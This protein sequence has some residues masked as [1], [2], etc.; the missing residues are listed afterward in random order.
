[1]DVAS[2]EESNGGRKIVLRRL[3]QDELVVRLS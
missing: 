1:V 3:L 2:D